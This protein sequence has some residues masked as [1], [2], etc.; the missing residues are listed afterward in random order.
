MKCYYSKYNCDECVYSNVCEVVD[1][2]MGVSEGLDLWQSIL[3]E[4]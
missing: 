1:E 2:L 4:S 3:D